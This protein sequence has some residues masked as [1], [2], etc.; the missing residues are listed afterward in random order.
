M[1]ALMLTALLASLAACAQAEQPKATEATAPQASTPRPAL[2][3]ASAPGAVRLLLAEEALDPAS[4]RVFEIVETRLPWREGWTMTLAGPETFVNARVGADGTVEVRRRAEDGGA[5]GEAAFLDALPAPDAFPALA[6]T[7]A[8]AEAL[9]GGGSPLAPGHI[10]HYVVCTPAKPGSGRA[11]PN[12]CRRDVPRE[13]W[14][15]YLKT[16]PAS[17][18]GRV[19]KVRFADGGEGTV[20]DGPPGY[21]EPR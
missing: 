19:R 4:V 2:P 16:M 8:R 3:L 17:G 14:R 21:F 15:V 6:P 10:V 7:L 9:V 1:K 18:E 12:G 13:E 20:S 11:A 5:Y